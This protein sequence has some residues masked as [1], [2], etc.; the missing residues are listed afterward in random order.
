MADTQAVSE[1]KPESEE[2]VQRLEAEVE[3][4]KKRLAALEKENEE[5]KTQL[6]RACLSADL[7]MR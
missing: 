3:Q 5:L 4:L 7:I 6:A 1:G 2:K